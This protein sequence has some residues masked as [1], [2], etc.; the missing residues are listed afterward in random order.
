[1]AGA[2]V[3]AVVVLALS[4]VLGWSITGVGMSAQPD[5]ATIVANAAVG[6]C[7]SW[8]KP[9]Q[10]D[11]AEV[12]CTQPHVFEI[13]GSAD[14]SSDYP[15]GAPFPA[16]AAWQGITTTHCANSATGYVGT[17]DPNGKYVVSALKPTEQQWSGGDRSL[18]CGLQSSTP[19]GAAFPTTGTAK[20]QD[21]SPVFPAGT[22]LALVSGAPGGPVNCTDQH[23]YEIVGIVDLSSSF[24]GGYPAVTDQQAKLA[25]LCQPILNSY[26]GGGSLSAYQLSLTWDTIQQQSWDAG[27][28]KVNCKVGSLS[29]DGSSLAPVTGSIKGIGGAPSPAAPSSTNG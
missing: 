22:C 25:Q 6:G 9:D 27:S 15:A 23:A 5:P 29:S 16:L 13:T 18:R 19:S 21:Q 2:S 10:S 3:G 24:P 1:M 20:G 8:S 26:T 17:L 4:V 28:H 11:L 12:D 7:L 14:L